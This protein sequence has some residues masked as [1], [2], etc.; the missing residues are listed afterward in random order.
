MAGPFGQAQI[1]GQDIEAALRRMVAA[2]R[3]QFAPREHP[4]LPSLLRPSRRRMMN[5]APKTRERERSPFSKALKIRSMFTSIFASEKCGLS[6][7]KKLLEP[8]GGR[9]KKCYNKTLD[10]I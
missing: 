10:S 7:C 5:L 2:R 8:G 9:A 4:G 6:E 1:A 3:D